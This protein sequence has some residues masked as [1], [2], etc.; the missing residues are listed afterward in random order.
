MV[1]TG[2]EIPGFPSQAQT[3]HQHLDL[4]P[5]PG[6]LEPG[7]QCLEARMMGSELPPTWGYIMGKII[8]NHHESWEFTYPTIYPSIYPTIY[9]TMCFSFF[10]SFFLSFFL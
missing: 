1:D 5:A 6:T 2:R 4:R 7:P 9:P 8:G 10:V 3:I